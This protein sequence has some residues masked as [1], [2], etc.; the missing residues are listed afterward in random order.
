ML[1]WVFAGVLGYFAFFV[2]V[3]YINVGAK[4]VF[5]K[6]LNCNMLECMGLGVFIDIIMLY[7][8]GF[9]MGGKMFWNV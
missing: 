3:E 5:I 1:N 4:R 7:F 6:V 8:E 2:V 9:C